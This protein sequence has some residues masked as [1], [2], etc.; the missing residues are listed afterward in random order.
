MCISIPLSSTHILRTTTTASLALQGLANY[1]GRSSSRPLVVSFAVKEPVLSGSVC[2]LSAD[3]LTFLH[4]TCFR[5][6]SVS[7][8]EQFVGTFL[9]YR[10]QRLP[11]YALES[12]SILHR[13]GTQGSETGNGYHR[14]AADF[15]I[16]RI[17]AP[18]LRRANMCCL[19]RNSN[20]FHSV[21]KLEILRLRESYASTAMGILI[22]CPNLQELYI[23]SDHFF[24]SLVDNYC[25]A[26]HLRVLH[27]EGPFDVFSV[28]FS[29]DAPLLD[30]LRLSIEGSACHG[31]HCMLTGSMYTS[32][33]CLELDLSGNRELW[34][35]T[36]AL[37]A[38]N[39]L[40]ELSICEY[41]VP[42]KVE[43]NTPFAPLFIT[44]D[45]IARLR[46]RNETNFSIL[47]ELEKLALHV[48]SETEVYWLLR[49]LPARCRLRA[50]RMISICLC[51]A[52]QRHSAYP[53]HSFGYHETIQGGEWN[54]TKVAIMPEW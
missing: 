3:A 44:P 31:Q 27:I 30:T 10:D 47:P 43:D 32:L 36:R 28:G 29:L 25:E 41:S 23:H 34:G 26:K 6:K 17:D 53:S 18:Q 2:S 11:M 21:E 13:T 49:A 24:A 40:S 9:Q 12:F 1:L 39:S 42:L 37:R 48:D 15:N 16:A 52:I 8:P 33:R 14:G 35:L 45:F 4:T 5:W 38:L 7:I 20:I 19:F 22:E 46:E 50:N 51:S 54:G